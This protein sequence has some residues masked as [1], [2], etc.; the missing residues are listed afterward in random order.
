MQ[1]LDSCF[2]HQPFI[3]AITAMT[4]TIL[5]KDYFTDII[6]DLKSRREL[7][8]RIVNEDEKPLE[9]VTVKLKSTAAATATDKNG[10]FIFDGVE[11]K[12]NVLEVSHVGYSTEI[13][14]VKKKDG[15]HIR[16]EVNPLSLDVVETKAYTTSIKRYNLGTS[17][18]ITR[19]E[20][21]IQPV[22][23][24]LAALQARVSGL[25]AV[26][27]SGLPGS[28]FNIQIRGQKSVGI[29]PGALPPNSPLFVVDGVPFLSGAETM[30]QTS[31]IMANSPFSTFN[32]ED[33]ESIEILK[34]A[35]STSIYGSIGANGVVLINTRKPKAGKTMVDV[36]MTNGWGKVARTMDFMNTQQYLEMRKEALA[37]DG[38]VATVD[39]AM[40][41]LLWDSTRYTNWKKEL[42]GGTANLSNA[43][44]RIW[45][46]A[47][48]TQF[49]ASLGYNNEMTVFP[50]SSR[51]SLATVTIQLFHLSDNKKLEFS[52]AGNYG[53]DISNLLTNDLT[54][55]IEFSAPNAPPLFDSLGRLVFRHNGKLFF[56]PY[57]DVSKPY[58]VVTERITSNIKLKYKVFPWLFFKGNLGYNILM[59]EEFAAILVSAQ[60]S[61]VTPRG[62]AN[63]GTSQRKNWVVEPQIEIVKSIGVKDQLKILFGSSWRKQN[64]QTT[65]ITASGFIHDALI[66]GKD[67]SSANNVAVSDDNHE[68]RIQSLYSL[69]NYSFHNRYLVEFTGRRDGSSRFGPKNQFAFFGSVAAGW[70]FSN[71]RF[72][73]KLLPFISYGKLRFSYGTS[74]NDQIGDYEFLDT[75]IS[76]RY[77]YLP[78]NESF[79]PV[80]LY[81]NDFT[82]ELHK[83]SDFSL[84]LGFLDDR[85]LLSV[86][87]NQTK[88]N[89]QLISYPL[90]SQTGFVRMIKN[91]KGSVGNTN[92]EMELSTVNLRKNNLKWKTSFNFTVSRNKLLQFPDLPIISYNSFYVV[93]QPLNIM[94]GY[95]TAGVNPA[96]GLYQILDRNGNVISLPNNFP[97]DA[98]VVKLDDYNPNVY[99][100]LYNSLHFNNWQLDI[101]LQFV[102]QKGLNQVTLLSENAGFFQLNQPA[103]VLN[104]WRKPGDQQP[105]QQYTQDAFSTAYLAA[106][107]SSSSDRLITNASYIRLKT[108]SLAYSLPF[109]WIRKLKVNSC[110]LAFQAQN[111]LTLTA[112]K[113]NHDPENGTINPK[114]LPPLRM[115]AFTIK[116]SF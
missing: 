97:S 9:G 63:F 96:T 98:D 77:P 57:S 67:F 2:A 79:I 43:H 66:L 101:L 37:N 62:E 53:Y 69:I 12:L 88:T 108:L 51:K 84:D 10:Y 60:D 39:N 55:A 5:P 31:R 95:R 58:K 13:I 48:Q 65:L 86:L 112:Y 102:N 29:R 40:D 15:I 52:Y 110:T 14:K 24:P 94:S 34:D 42:I 106:I 28:G 68:Y 46:G 64:G 71:E 21:N 1:A 104:R 41:L 93:G 33:I 38:A 99:G 59:A 76:N 72:F 73:E 113:G 81:N 26:Q 4:V 74:G 83:S 50:G 6:N 7:K 75:W 91:V 47:E 109:K 44:I 87:W 11:Q 49:T 32:M 30:T 3:Y 78:R 105:Y 70:I 56:N 8:G 61:A 107:L 85:I 92:F 100:G 36:T 20:I 19:E 18:R 17:K 82:W 114:G 103:I 22:S 27:Q 45:C 90:P 35:N 23:N 16:L 80:K 25:V 116:S 89:N 115:L 54:R 111:L